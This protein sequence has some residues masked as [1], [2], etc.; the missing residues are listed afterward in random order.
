M[1]LG[2][3][4]AFFCCTHNVIRV[5]ATGFERSRSEFPGYLQ[6]KKGVE[7]CKIY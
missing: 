3:L 1:F 7:I 2:V 6:R 4:A 5:H